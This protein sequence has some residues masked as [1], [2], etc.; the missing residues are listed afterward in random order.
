MI[1][2]WKEIIGQEQKGISGNYSFYNGGWVK[3]VEAVDKSQSNGY[4]FEGK[5]VRGATEGMVEIG[6]GFYIVCSIE[7]SRK[8]QRK[9][10]AVYRLTGE[11]VDRIIGWVTGKDWALKIRDKLAELLTAAASPVELSTEEQDLVEQLR[12]LSP[13]RLEAVLAVLK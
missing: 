8:N 9:E 1:I 11:Q 3:K 6:D 2:N 10:Y 7:G 13:D 5:F 4:C 12:A